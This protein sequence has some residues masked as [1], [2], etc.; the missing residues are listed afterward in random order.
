MAFNK[1]RKSSTPDIALPALTGKS[2]PTISR[3]LCIDESLNDSGAALFVDCVY[4]KVIDEESKDN[5]GLFLTIKKNQSQVF[6]IIKYFNW[7]DQ[8][9][10]DHN[11]DVVIGETH[12]FTRGNLKTSSATLEVMAGIRYITMLACGLSSVPYVEFST[13]HVKTIMCGAPSASK[14]MVQMILK[15]CGYDLPVYWGQAQEIN[16]NVCDA[17]AMGEVICRMQKQEILRMQYS[18][19]VG[20]GRSQ[21]Q[22]RASTK[23]QG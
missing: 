21:T 14:E 9:I 18:V 10:K 23:F 17:I 2:W 12:P 7:V 16:G 3:I 5:I 15:G 8:M 22:K 6:K 20:P 13:N 19:V 1:S 4:Q 11:P